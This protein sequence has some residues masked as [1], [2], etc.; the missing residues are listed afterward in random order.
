MLVLTGA[1]VSAES[2]MPTFRGED[3]LWKNYRAEE[4]ATPH[5]FA[6]NPE[7]VWEWYAWRRE[8]LA[9][10]R[11]NPGHLAL[12]RWMGSRPGVTLVTQNV[13]GLHEAAADAVAR[14][15]GHALPA[16]VKLHGSI[17]HDRCTKCAHRA[18]AAE[19][20]GTIP[21][22]PRCGASLRPDVVWFGET[23][24]ADQLTM[25]SQAASQ[26]A[27]C[28]AVGTSGV[29][30]PAAGLAYEALGRGAK[31]LVVDPGPT[32]LDRD[33][34]VILRGPAGEVVPQLLT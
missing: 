7:L 2:G 28:L 8:R 13:D 4:L 5:A 1:G 16:P 32:A 26:A 9:E 12:A 23:L 27:V 18:A 14:E 15:L 22:C 33:A 25:A 29:V 34:D 21:T 24:P 10:C 17:V 19:W 3:G 31:L 11:P 20:K 6:R 30:Y